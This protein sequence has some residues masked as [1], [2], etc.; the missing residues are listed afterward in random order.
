MGV[1]VSAV[2]RLLDQYFTGEDEI[3]LNHYSFTDSKVLLGVPP[4]PLIGLDYVSVRYAAPQTKRFQC[5]SGQAIFASN[6]NRSG[7]VEVG[8]MAGSLTQGYIDVQELLGIPYPII[9]EDNK[10]GGTSQVIANQCRL[11]ETPEWKRQAVPGL[12]IYTFETAE[13]AVAHGIRLPFVLF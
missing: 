11:V 3:A 2:A 4:A 5:L 9:I 13:I 6:V 10:S 12:T 7:V 8:M 1:D